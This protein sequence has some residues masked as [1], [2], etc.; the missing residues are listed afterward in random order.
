M[1]LSTMLTWLP[2]IFNILLAVVNGWEGNWNKSMYWA[3]ASLLTVGI[4][5]M[6][7]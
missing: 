3:G 1:A 4:L 2:L 6:E 5:R 7:N